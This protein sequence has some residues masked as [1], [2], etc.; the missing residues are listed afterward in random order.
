[1][2]FFLNI[3]TGQV[4]KTSCAISAKGWQQGL[5]GLLQVVGS[6]LDEPPITL[7]IRLVPERQ[8]LLGGVDRRM[9]I[10]PD[11]LGTDEPSFV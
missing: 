7:V 10:L 3:L 9:D 8:P 2:L 6:G 1:M 5:N 4:I 11:P